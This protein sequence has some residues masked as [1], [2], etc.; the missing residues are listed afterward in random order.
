ME[1]VNQLVVSQNNEGHLT[2]NKRY[3]NYKWLIAEVPHILC[4]LFEPVPLLKFYFLKFLIVL[5]PKY[6]SGPGYPVV[7]RLRCSLRLNCLYPDAFRAPSSISRTSSACSSV[8]LPA[9]H[10]AVHIAPYITTRST[11]LYRLLLCRRQLEF[12]L[13]RNHYTTEA[14]RL[15]IFGIDPDFFLCVPVYWE[16]VWKRIVVLVMEI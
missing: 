4:L 14:R 9:R 10:V 3:E 12:A 11:P 6:Y 2:P 8:Y 5:I 15:G 13:V 16:R 1:L 7:P